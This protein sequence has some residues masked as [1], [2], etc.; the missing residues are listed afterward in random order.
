MVLPESNRF[1]GHSVR[2]GFKSEES[3]LN[4]SLREKVIFRTAVLV[5]N[6]FRIGK[7]LVK[8]QHWWKLPQIVVFFG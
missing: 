6:S 1:D 5:L 4:F 8:A 3:K 7:E 2:V